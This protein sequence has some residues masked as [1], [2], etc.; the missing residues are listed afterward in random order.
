[1][2]AVVFDGVVAAAAV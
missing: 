1:L 2:Y